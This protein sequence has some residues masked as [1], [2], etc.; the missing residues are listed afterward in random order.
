M[1]MDTAVGVR[2][3]TQAIGSDPDARHL[4]PGHPAAEMV[5]LLGSDGA[6]LACL[7]GRLRAIEWSL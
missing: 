3:Q 1:T 6:G 5:S 4:E 2:R 7:A